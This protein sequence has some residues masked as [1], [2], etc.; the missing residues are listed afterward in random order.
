MHVENLDKH[1]HAQTTKHA[2]YARVIS[3]PWPL[4]L[5]VLLNLAC[6]LNTYSSH[7]KLIIVHSI[8]KT[9]LKLFLGLDKLFG[10]NQIL[11]HFLASQ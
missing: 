4:A 8:I 5:Q 1:V 2:L 6:G 3:P 11:A 10:L 7:A 9:K